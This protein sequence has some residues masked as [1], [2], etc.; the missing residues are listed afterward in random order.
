MKK[1]AATALFLIAAL[2][3]PAQTSFVVLGDMHMDKFDFHDMDFVYTRPSDWKQIT[4]EFPYYTAAYVPKLW[5][6]VSNRVG[7][8]CSAVIQLGDLMEGVCGNQELSEQMAQW[9]VGQIDRASGDATAILVKGNH[10]VSKSPGQPEAWKKHVLPYIR[11]QTGQPELKN[12]MYRYSIGTDADLF[13]AE[14]FFSPDDML[15]ESALLE[16][17]KAELPK[18]EGKYR[19][20]LTHQPVIPVSQRCWHLFSGLRRRVEN[21]EIREEFLNLLAQ[22]K[23]TVLCAHLHEYS[24]IVRETD[25]GNIVQLMMISTVNSFEPSKREAKPRAYLTENDVKEEWSKRTYEERKRIIAQEGRH[26]KYY[27]CRKI[28]GYAVITIS[29]KGAEFSF[30]RGYSDTPSESFLIDDLYRL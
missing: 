7:E 21:P 4:T 29:E 13:V 11:R 18:S 14:Q 25:N 15:P 9:S 19:F 22:Y 12:G 6:A 16:F 8:G 5:N 10:D 28:P 27:T 17:L 26:V 2:S 23:V 1:S 30:Y 24:Q 20:L 3:L